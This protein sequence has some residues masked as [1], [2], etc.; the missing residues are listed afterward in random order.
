MT[1]HHAA[2]KWVVRLG[3]RVVKFMFLHYFCAKNRILVLFVLRQYEKRAFV[4]FSGGYLV[5][6]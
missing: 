2:R 4:E 1:L 3:I 6:G 5:G